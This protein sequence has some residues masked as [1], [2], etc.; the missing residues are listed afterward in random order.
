M[1]NGETVACNDEFS[2]WESDE[3]LMGELRSQPQVEVRKALVPF[4]AHQ[5]SCSVCCFRQ[6]IEQRRL[7]TLFRPRPS[8]VSRDCRVH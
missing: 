6:Q 5:A 2:W 4:L 7:R 3:L 8:S 1:Q